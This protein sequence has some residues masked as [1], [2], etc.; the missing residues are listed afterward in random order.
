MLLNYLKAQYYFKISYK[1]R[2][3]PIFICNFDF[4]VDKNKT[5]LKKNYKNL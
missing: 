4:I 1:F 5:K 2:N 3:S